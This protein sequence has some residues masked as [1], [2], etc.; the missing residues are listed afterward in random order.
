MNRVN[1]AAFVLLAVLLALVWLTR[2]NVLTGRNDFVQLYAGGSLAGTGNLYS[3]EASRQTILSALGV[4]IQGVPWF[5]R[6]PF[7]AVLLH[8]LSRL[9]YLAAYAVFTALNLCAMFAFLALFRKSLPNLAVLAAMTLPVYISVLLGQDTLLLLALAAGSFVLIRAGREFTG[10]MLMALCAIKFHVFLVPWLVTAWFRRRAGWGILAGGIV[11]VVL[12]FMAGGPSWPRDYAAR[13]ASAELHPAGSLMPTFRA[14][15][16]ALGTSD[17]WTTATGSAVTL[18]VVALIVRRTRSFEISFAMSLVAGIL[19]AW[20]AYMQDAVILL[21]S[22]A[23]I[24]TCPADKLLRTALLLLLM[25]PLWFVLLAGEPWSGLVPL[26]LLAV[27][28]LA[29]LRP[30][31]GKLPLSEGGRGPSQIDVDA[32]RNG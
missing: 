28:I 21:L 10:G 14:L 29:A 16:A 3:P 22:A 18:F 31:A 15:A 9:P 30:F 17:A 8:P 23:I 20:H 1:I 32:V 13:S 2:E 26:A 25:P 7:Y 19:L 11:L 24:L 27:L 4:T 5:S 12:S 6:L